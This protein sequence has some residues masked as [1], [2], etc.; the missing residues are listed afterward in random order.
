MQGWEG[1]IIYL[2]LFFVI[3]Y[4]LLIRP[5]QRQQKQRQE[6]LSQ[7]KVNDRIVTAGGLHGRIIQLKDSTAIVRIA[8]KVEVEVQ[9]S[10]IGSVLGRDS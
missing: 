5:Q 9:R 6:M 3:F 1:T 8:D 7:L 10:A 2:G 4:F